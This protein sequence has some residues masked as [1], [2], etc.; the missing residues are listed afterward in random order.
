MPELNFHFVSED[1]DNLD[2]LHRWLSYELSSA[3][4]SGLAFLV[5]YKY[6]ADLLTLAAVIFT[7][8]MLWRLFKAR[9][10]GWIVGFFITVGFPFLLGRFAGSTG[11]VAGFLLSV[12]PL[13]A[14]YFYTWMLRLKTGE[15]LLDVEPLEGE[16]ASSQ[17]H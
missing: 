2:K 3:G 11:M 6:I 14:F 9:R 5:P 15:W 8:Y 7:P 13:I 1:Y 17:Q 4:L 16:L 12:F 10:F